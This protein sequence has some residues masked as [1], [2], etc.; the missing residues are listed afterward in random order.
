MSERPERHG[1]RW[2]DAELVVLD[3]LVVED[4]SWTE[5]GARLQRKPDVVRRRAMRL[6]FERYYQRPVDP[7]AQADGCTSRGDQ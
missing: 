4:V 7:P 6:A 3:R 5:I 2:T 1:H